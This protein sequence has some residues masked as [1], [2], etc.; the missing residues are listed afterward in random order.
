[1]PLSSGDWN[2]NGNGWAGTLSIAVD[3]AGNINGTVYG[4]PIQGFWYEAAQRITFLRSPN[5]D[6]SK[7]QIYTGYLFRTADIYTLAGSFQGFAGSGGVAR[8][9]TFGWFS[10]KSA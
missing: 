10:Q 4:N 1:M 2:I 8:R 9:A 5:S 7:I 3:G 6:P